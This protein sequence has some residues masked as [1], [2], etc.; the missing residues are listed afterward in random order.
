MNVLI[1]DDMETD[2]ANLRKIL[3]EMGHI[4]EAVGSGDEAVARAAA[5]QPKAIFLDVV[6]PKMDGFAACRALK[7]NPATKGIPIVMVTSKGTPA[8]QFWAQQQGA[9]AHVTKPATSTEIAAALRK[10]GV[11]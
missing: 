2:R 6:M 7:N 10:A 9:A 4:V 11:G 5:T 3:A 1:C 8:D